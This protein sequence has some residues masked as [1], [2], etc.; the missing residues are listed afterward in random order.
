MNNRIVAKEKYLI[1]NADDFGLS[2]GVN[3][4]ILRAYRD[5]ILTSASLMVRQPAAVTA[6][7]GAGDLPLGL[8]VDLGEWIFDQDQWLARYQRVSLE[9]KQSIRAEVDFQLSEFERLTGRLPTHLD[10]HQHVHKRPIVRQ[11][12]FDKAKELEIP[13]RFNSKGIS[14]CGEFYGQSHLGAAHPEAITVANLQ[15]LIRLLPEQ[16]TELA[17]HPGE[18]PCL[19]SVYCVERITEVE[20]L[21]SPLILETIRDERVKLISFADLKDSRVLG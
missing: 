15:R 21:C 13:L 18:D 3:Q 17:C 6:I 7:M 20:T 9:D 1:V 2:E 5:G 4:G 11:V 8:H 16:M 14:Y 19:N 12:F 10:S